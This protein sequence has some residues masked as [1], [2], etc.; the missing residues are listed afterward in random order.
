MSRE[1]S[2]AKIPIFSQL[3]KGDL[4]RL[5]RIAVPRSFKTGEVIIKEGDRAAGVFLVTSG[6]VEVVKGADERVATCGPGEFFGEMALFE[7][8]PRS[9]TVRALEDTELLALTRWDFT[10][11]LKNHPEIAVSM[12]PLLVRRLRETTEAQHS[13]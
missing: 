2:L 1:D 5:A 6:R 12:L 8:Y 4:A 9:A 7:D 3:G 10:A 11:E 13:D